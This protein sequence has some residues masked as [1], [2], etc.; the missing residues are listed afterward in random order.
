MK[1]ACSHLQAF[2]IQAVLSG[3]RLNVRAW[4]SA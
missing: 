4:V 3:M 1:T 2:F